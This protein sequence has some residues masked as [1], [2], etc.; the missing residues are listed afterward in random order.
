MPRAVFVF[1]AGEA[2]DSVVAFVTTEAYEQRP[3]Q[4]R[5]HRARSQLF[6]T[7]GILDDSYRRYGV[8]RGWFP[9]DQYLRLSRQALGIAILEEC[10]KSPNSFCPSDNL[11]GNVLSWGNTTEGQDGADERLMAYLKD[12]GKGGAVPDSVCGYSPV[13]GWIVERECPGLSTLKATNPLEFR[14]KSLRTHFARDDIKAALRRGGKPLSL[15][16]GEIST[17][18]YPP[19]DKRAGCDPETAQCVACPLERAY[20]G[21]SCCVLVSRPMVSMKVRRTTKRAAADAARGACCGRCAC[22]CSRAQH[23]RRDARIPHTACHW[24]TRPAS[25]RTHRAG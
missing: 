14:V 11:A 24:T 21:V 7:T 4:T 12:V 10:K 3:S 19:C 18:F 6:A 17:P 9:P 1:A 13:P 8:E 15:G 22:A 5:I 23:Q 2:C 16:L 25:P 20:A